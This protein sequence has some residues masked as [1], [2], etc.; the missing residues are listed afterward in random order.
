M[1]DIFRYFQCLVQLPIVKYQ[2]SINLGLRKKYIEPFVCRSNKHRIGYDLGM[3][4]TSLDSILMVVMICWLGLHLSGCASLSK[5]ECQNAN[6]YSIGFSDG[7]K[8]YKANRQNQHR[9]ACAE[10]NIRLDPERY[11]EGWH[12]GLRQYCVPSRAYQSG[13]RGY[14]FNNVCP[15]ELAPSLPHAYQDGLHIYQ[16]KVK[17]GKKRARHRHLHEKIHSL[18]EMLEQ[19]QKM[20]NDR[21]LPREERRLTKKEIQLLKREIRLDERQLDK[22]TRRIRVLSDDIRDHQADARD[23]WLVH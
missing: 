22:M 10:H 6:W 8:G 1:I 14:A 7:A 3:R 23:R 4:F 12:R 13:L 9:K 17:L 20:L 16:M 5:Q 21:Q 18:N 19:K 11:L 15:T 2:Q